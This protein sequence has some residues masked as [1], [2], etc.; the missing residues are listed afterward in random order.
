MKSTQLKAFETLSRFHSDDGILHEN[1]PNMFSNDL[2]RRDCGLS[3]KSLYLTA[4][5]VA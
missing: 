1:F 3:G 2:F 5:N 4:Q